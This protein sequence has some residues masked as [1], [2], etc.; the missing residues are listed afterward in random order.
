MNQYIVPGRLPGCMHDL[1]EET[2]T[3]NVKDDTLYTQSQKKQIV[4]SCV[5]FADKC[6]QINFVLY[7]ILPKIMGETFDIFE[8]GF[9][10]PVSN[11]H[12]KIRT[13]RGHLTLTLGFR[14]SQ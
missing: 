3:C 10:G 6:R 11:S 4:E 1:W 9:L 13:C 2:C 12:D 14:G 5:S 7:F 8:W